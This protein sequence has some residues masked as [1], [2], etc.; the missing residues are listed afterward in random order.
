[1][2]S[3]RLNN[4]V[5]IFGQVE[6][7]RGISLDVADGE[8]VV[9]VGPS[10]CG[11]ST[12][13]RIVAGLETAT[14]GDVI[15]NGSI[16]NDTPAA[17]RGLAMVFQSYALYPH[18]SV[19]QNLSF[20]LENARLPKAEIDARVQRAARML[21]IE[22]LL[23]RKPRQ[24]SGGQRQ[25]VAIGRAITRKPQIFLFDE[26]LSN[27]DAELRVQMR[28]ELS[29]LHSDLAATMIHVTH[30]QVEAMTMASK[31]V[32]LRDGRIEQVGAPLDVYNCPANRF[33]AGFIGSPRMNFMSG[34]ISTHADG[35]IAI[36]AQGLPPVRVQVSGEGLSLG[37]EVTLGIRPEHLA[38]TSGE[39]WPLVVEVVEQLG[40][41]SYIH[42][43]LPDGERLTLT[44]PGQ[45]QLRSGAQV[46]VAP[47]P[48]CLHVFRKDRDEVALRPV[49][50]PT[51][52]SMA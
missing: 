14:S 41:T 51:T 37:D 26:P 49:Q 47:A 48:D 18:M 42:A 33:V 34:R 9:F 32:V 12:L 7:I 2:A 43:R 3:L 52:V 36:G 46:R 6:V 31:I 1:M 28:V 50:A 13:L 38:P 29:K 10:G 23:A 27:L 19:Y 40:G 15:L 17:E 35:E 39:G 45:T 11:K 44:E 24:L 20:G 16:V 22:G 4:V 8:F 5:K 21:Q 30:D 25:R